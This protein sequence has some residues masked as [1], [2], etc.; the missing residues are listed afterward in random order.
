MEKVKYYLIAFFVFCLGLLK[1]YWEGGEQ[2]KKE[3]ENEMIKKKQK[4]IKE[5]QEIEN[6]IQSI[7][8]DNLVDRAS[9]WLRK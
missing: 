2:K 4:A 1:I 8:K 3:I 5:K 6:E 7:S 9:K